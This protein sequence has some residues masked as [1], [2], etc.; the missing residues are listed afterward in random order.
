MADWTYSDYVTYDHDS[1]RVT[2]LR[3]HVQEVSNALNNYKSQGYSGMQG[4]KFELQNYLTQI[5]TELRNLEE[6]LGIGPGNDEKPFVR[7]HA[8]DLCDLGD[9]TDE[10]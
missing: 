7:L 6:R 8:R 2:R 4:G 5:K 3:L 10:T 9:D 1:S